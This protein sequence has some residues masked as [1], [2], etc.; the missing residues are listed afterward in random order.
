MTKLCLNIFSQYLPINTNV[1]CQVSRTYWICRLNS[2]KQPGG[3][4]GTQIDF[5]WFQI[6]NFRRDL[7]V[8]L[9][10]GIDVLVFHNP[11]ITSE[12][13]KSTE[14]KKNVKSISQTYQSNKGALSSVFMDIFSCGFPV[15]EYEKICYVEIRMWPFQWR[16]RDLIPTG[17]WEF[18]TNINLRASTMF[19]VKWAGVW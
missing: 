11:D 17:C 18:E 14:L 5:R 1:R 12:L 7:I 9:K 13:C 2:F 16:A 3:T 4:R 6:I 15:V 10:Q 19:Q 8:K